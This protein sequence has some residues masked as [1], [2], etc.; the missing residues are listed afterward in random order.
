MKAAPIPKN[1]KERLGSLYQSALLDTEPEERFDRITRTATKLFDV[2]ISTLTLIDKKREWFKSACGIDE[3]EG[4]RAIS[5]C[6]HALTADEVLVIPDTKK[7]ARFFDNP[8]V[9]GKPFIRFFAGVPI[10][11]SDGQRIG[12]L[13][14]KDTKPRKFS[15]SKQELLISLSAWA[16]LEINSRNMSLALNS[17]RKLEAKLV[18]Q[19][20]EM[21]NARDAA[22]N[23]LEDLQVEKEELTRAKAKD[24]A[25]LKSIADG[26]VAIDQDRKIMLMN[27]KAEEILGWSAREMVGKSSFEVWKV[28]DKNGKLIP[29]KN[30]P[31]AAAFRG[32]TIIAD[33]S[34][35]YIRKDG[36][37]FPV[38]MTISPVVVKNKIV[39]VVAVFHDITR[40]QEIDHAKNSF[41][42][43]ASHQLRTPLTS[44]NWYTEMLLDGDTGKL[45]KN[46]R[47]FLNEI[48][49]GS[50][51]MTSLV[52]SLLNV[53]RLDIG[54]F[55]VNP[56]KIN[57]ILVFEEMLRES[58]KD[59]QG[60]KLKI[61]TDFDNRIPS[62]NADPNLTRIIVQNL[63]TN[64][65]K[66]TPTSGRIRIMVRQKQQNIIITV[67]DNGYGIPK[68][69]QNQVFTKLFRADNVKA[70]DT[71]GTG[72]G[73]YIVKSI[74]DAIG[75]SISFESELNKGT[76]FTVTL[77]LQGMKK[78]L[79]T[80]E[81]AFMK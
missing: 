9:I 54:T 60:K 71:K 47:D 7:D 34:Y 56:E 51:R 45:T 31:I 36:S 68:N 53:S 23:V 70:K 14:I 40:E 11:N 76:T 16:E 8:M 72:L 79:G 32:K 39:G 52:N 74:L 77:P 22:R 25:L 26:V 81:L 50:L 69:Q 3:K 20:K 17:R 48:H 65:V 19:E 64:A 10:L 38:S 28:A 66:Y 33:K 15:K 24:E 75:G 43:L 61:T 12:V 59:I 42:A 78:R 1:E 27:K 49:I 18:I 35:F 73:L 13:C 6:G 41:I 30:L 2:P 62:I 46:Q 37:R 21:K 57:L 80:R 63:I 44:I 4:K 58:Y 29:K 67:A 55:I 5:F